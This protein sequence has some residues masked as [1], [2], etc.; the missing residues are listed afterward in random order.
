MRFLID[1][2]TG[3]AVAKWL[4]EQGHDV[5]SVADS[6]PGWKDTQ[7][8]ERAATDDR[9]I[10]TN[11][12]DFGELIFKNQ[13]P[14]RGAVLLRLSDETSANKIAVLARL[15][16]THQVQIRPDAF[17]TVTEQSVRVRTT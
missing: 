3:P 15:M 2:C 9:I 5:Y 12:R 14:H 16:Q 13:L 4:V 1:E 8:L 6:S 10:I 11:D 17:I 7:V